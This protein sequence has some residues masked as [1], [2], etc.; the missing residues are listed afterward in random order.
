MAY[1]SNTIVFGLQSTASAVGVFSQSFRVGIKGAVGINGRQLHH[2]VDA[3]RFC[4]WKG[5]SEAREVSVWNQRSIRDESARF[6]WGTH[7]MTNSASKAKREVENFIVTRELRQ[8]F[9][10]TN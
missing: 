5:G 10:E 4:I 7:T 1:E 8:I 3:G 9:S 6:Q 2:G